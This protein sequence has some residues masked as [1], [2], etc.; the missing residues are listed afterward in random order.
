M[1]VIRVVH[2]YSFIVYIYSV[3]EFLYLVIQ[4][5]IYLFI[6]FLYFIV[7]IVHIRENCNTFD[8]DRPSNKNMP[9]LG[10]RFFTVHFA[11][12]LALISVSL[13]F[14]CRGQPIIQPNTPRACSLMCARGTSGDWLA[15]DADDLVKLFVSK[16]SKRVQWWFYMCHN[17]VS[18]LQN[19]KNAK[20]PW[21]ASSAHAWPRDGAGKA[22]RKTA[23]QC[24]SPARRASNS[25]ARA[26][27][28]KCDVTTRRG[29]RGQRPSS[30]AAPPLQRCHDNCLSISA[31]WRHRCHGNYNS[32]LP[33]QAHQGRI[34]RC[35]HN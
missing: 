8:N 23:R 33:P 1:R 14:N 29:S 12:T 10:T 22:A 17:C 5:C 30:S 27:C 19:V 28:M 3:I 7:H 9:N 2:I 15:N 16:V 20:Q 25:R 26:R 32:F 11:I 18:Q 6:Y 24:A 13:T 35:C 21:H 4:T 34:W 31:R